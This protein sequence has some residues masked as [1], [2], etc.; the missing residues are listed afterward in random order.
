MFT[1][2]VHE[3]GSSTHLGC[4]LQPGHQCGDIVSGGHDMS[5]LWNQFL[6]IEVSHWVY[7]SL[8]QTTQTIVGYLSCVR[9]LS[10]QHLMTLY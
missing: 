4:I 10:F 9:V 3:C 7:V 5:L 1:L 8:A 2:V 6:A